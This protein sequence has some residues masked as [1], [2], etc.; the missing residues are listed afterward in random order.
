[1]RQISLTFILCSLDPTRIM[2]NIKLDW[3]KYQFVQETVA[4]F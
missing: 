4:L 1:M 2:K 3:E